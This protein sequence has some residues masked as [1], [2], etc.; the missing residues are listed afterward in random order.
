[1]AGG[2]PLRAPVVEDPQ[3]G[4][5]ECA[6]EAREAAIAVRQLEVGEEPWH[7]R[8]VDCVSTAGPLRERAR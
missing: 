1:L 5:A 6:E 4:L 8:V 2:E 3:I 7:A